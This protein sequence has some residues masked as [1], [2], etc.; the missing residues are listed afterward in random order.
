[1]AALTRVVVTKSVYDFVPQ[2]TEHLDQKILAQGNPNILNRQVSAKE[3]LD[4]QI[5]GGRDD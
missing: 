1:M 4:L 5:A 3:I 2:G